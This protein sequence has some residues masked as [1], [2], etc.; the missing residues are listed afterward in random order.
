M[1]GKHRTWKKSLR[2]RNNRNRS[3]EFENLIGDSHD[4]RHQNKLSLPPALT[5]PIFQFFCP[6]VP[7]FFNRGSCNRSIIEQRHVKVKEGGAE[8]KKISPT[9]FLICRGRVTKIS[10][11]PKGGQEDGGREGVY[12]GQQVSAYSRPATIQSFNQQPLP[13]W[14][15]E[16]PRK[17]RTSPDGTPIHTV[18]AVLLYDIERSLIS[19]RKG[20]K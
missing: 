6:T 1:E 7:R 12:G 18:C 10:S 13:Q 3:R 17:E 8:R 11:S 19:P 14:W 5:F 16:Q 20:K 4:G 2:D 9:E 15:D